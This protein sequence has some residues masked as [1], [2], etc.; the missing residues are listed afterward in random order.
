MEG[1]S[2]MLETAQKFAAAMPRTEVSAVYV[3]VQYRRLLSS[4]LRSWHTL[5]NDAKKIYFEDESVGRGC[6]QVECQPEHEWR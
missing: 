6:R 2:M 5:T 1:S 4:S 3:V